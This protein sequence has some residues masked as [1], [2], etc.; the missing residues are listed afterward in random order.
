MD[1][2]SRRWMKVGKW[3]LRPEKNSLSVFTVSSFSLVG[4]KK[5]DDC[6]GLENLSKYQVAHVLPRRRQAKG[7]VFRAWVRL[8]RRR[9]IGVF[10]K[11]AS[12]YFTWLRHQRHYH[13]TGQPFRFSLLFLEVRTGPRSP[14]VF[15]FKQMRP[16]VT[17]LPSWFLPLLGTLLFS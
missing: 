7:N 11:L 12:S 3:N 5:Q 9:Q 6:L 15:F 4:A 13:F 1:G 14:I 16:F 2:W 17:T 10:R 8:F